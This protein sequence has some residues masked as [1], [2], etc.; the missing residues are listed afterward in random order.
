MIMFTGKAASG[1]FRS[2]RNIRLGSIAAVA[3][4]P[5]PLGKL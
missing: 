5:V 2:R 1:K 4:H 3:Q